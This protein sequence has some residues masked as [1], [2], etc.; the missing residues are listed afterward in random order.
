MFN[1]KRK[2]F[3]LIFFLAVLTHAYAQY[4]L[5]DEVF[6][7]TILIRNGDEMATAFKFDQDGRVF[8]VTTRFVARN[9]PSRNATVQVWHG[10][11]TDLPILHTVFPSSKDVDLAI[12]E[13]DE[14]IGSPYRVV[15]SS[16]VIT[17][18]Q[19]V[20]YMGWL[21]PVPHPPTIANLH[22]QRP[23]FP[24]VPM[25][26]I[27]A[28]AAIDPSRP[29]AFQIRV[30]GPYSLRIAAGPIVYWSPVHQDFELLGVIKRSDHDAVIAPN[31]GQQ[32]PPIVRTGILQA[33]GIDEVVD[34]IRKK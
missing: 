1:W 5:P 26:K 28:V 29:D 4:E 12:L 23:L 17:T 22:T 33:Y 25:V 14:R 15:R 18:G 20:W 10:S 2:E 7:R 21:A 32:G 30:D 27:G 3:L 11:W 9:L 31:Y 13:T 6:R 34:A 8:L 24:E 19:K 16:E